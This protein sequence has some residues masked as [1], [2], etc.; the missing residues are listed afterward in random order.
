MLYNSNLCR[1]Y[2]PI[3]RVIETKVT[4]QTDGLPAK[5]VVVKKELVCI[6]S[7]SFNESLKDVDPDQLEI[8][9][10]TGKRLDRVPSSVLAQDRINLSVPDVPSETETETQTETKTE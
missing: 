8:D 5:R 4:R 2:A 6:N 10:A 7:K 3:T 1:S 9:L